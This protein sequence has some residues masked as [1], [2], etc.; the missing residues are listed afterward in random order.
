[1]C[2]RDRRILNIHK[3]VPGVLGQVNSVISEEGGNIVAQSLSTE[4]AIGYLVVDVDLPE[5]AP[6]AERISKL[7]NSI[8][9]FAL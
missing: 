2:I 3:N 4:G 8:R 6:V 9:T 1:M 5:N 7:T